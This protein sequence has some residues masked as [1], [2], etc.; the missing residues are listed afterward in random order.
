MHPLRRNQGAKWTFIAWPKSRCI[1][2]SALLGP[3]NDPRNASRNV[4]ETVLR[5]S[6]I[7][8]EGAREQDSGAGEVIGRAAAWVAWSVCAVSLLIFA[9]S[10]VLIFAGWTTQLPGGWGSRQEQ[11]IAVVGFIGVPIVGGLIASHRPASSYGWL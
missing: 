4:W 5:Y 6:G 9:M 3:E 10:L 1:S 7:V 11:I 2:V 8:T